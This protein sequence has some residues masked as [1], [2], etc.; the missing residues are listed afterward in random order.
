MQV[1]GCRF[2]RQVGPENIST[3]SNMPPGGLRSLA[4]AGHRR[5]NNCM[6]SAYELAM[7]RLQKQAPTVKLSAGQKAAIAELESQ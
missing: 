3:P 2:R 7:E 4:A 1:E 5:Y 6:K